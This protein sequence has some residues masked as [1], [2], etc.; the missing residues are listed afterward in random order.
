MTTPTQLRLARM[1]ES[2]GAVLEYAREGREAFLADQR[3]QDA[4]MWRMSN[5][6]EEADKLWKELAR[7]NPRV[8]WRVL[9]KLRQEYHHEYSRLRPE[10]VW[11]F[12]DLRLPTL[13]SK[14]RRARVREPPEAPRSRRD[15]TI[16]RSGPP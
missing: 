5:F 2:G 3:L 10:D 14:L 4:V 7:D 13:M 12:I 8:D 1:V 16:D 9:T 11:E 15:R 6:T